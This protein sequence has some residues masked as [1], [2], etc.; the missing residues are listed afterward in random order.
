MST[1]QLTERELGLRRI[2]LEDFNEYSSRALF[3]RPK[4]G[5]LQRFSLNRAQKY[6]HER[7]QQQ[8]SLTGMIRAIIL[9]GRQQGCS[10]YIEGRFYWR[11]TH[12]KGVRAYILTHED[13]ATQ[14]LYEMA[15]RY[16][17]HCPQIL[18]PHT[19]ASNAKELY[20]DLLDS[21]YKVGTAGTKAVGR[22]SALQYFHG[23]EV[24]FWPFAED[25]AA[26]VMQGVPRG[27]DTEIILESTANGI[28]NFFHSTW[29]KA[30]M[31]QS[32]Y[33][34]IFLPWW[35]QTEYTADTQG[36]NPTP[37]EL[38]YQENSEEIT[39]GNLAWRRVKISEIGDDLFK[40]EYPASAAEAFQATGDDSYIKPAAVLRA[41]KTLVTHDDAPLICGLDPAYKGKDRTVF[42]FR[43][44]RRAYNSITLNGKDNMEVAG[45]CV[46]LLKS[47]VWLPDS[48]IPIQI[49]KVFVDLGGMPGIYDRLV[50]LGFSERVIGVNFGASA[51]QGT[52]YVNKRAEMWGLMNEWLKGPCQL[53]DSDTMQADLCGVQYSYDSSGR[54][55]LETKD[56]MRSRGLVSP[57]EGD[58][59]ALTFAMPVARDG[60]VTQPLEVR[61]PTEEGFYF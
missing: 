14:N 46:N 56:H 17:E 19:G 45:F 58:A 52:N 61:Q 6:I 42:A 44:G 9:K 48:S 27:D 39:A 43:R 60:F 54:L 57:D 23:S 35:W 22:S 21:G 40:R 38:A 11:V 12:R 41:R 49:R 25:H 5:D 15:T 16:H 28:G 3:I 26:G 50:E 32:D 7:L 13:S 30:E 1:P 2:L 51:I 8:L 18:R 24:A 4:Q 29:Q 59:M 47:G 53:P 31:G 20:F 10:T 37:D 36:F 34:A 55:K 33:I